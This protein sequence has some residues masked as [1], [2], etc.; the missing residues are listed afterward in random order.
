MPAEPSPFDELPNYLKR[1]V[2]LVAQGKTN[3][4]IAAEACLAPHTVE[5]YVS[6]IMERTG[7]RTRAKLVAEPIAWVA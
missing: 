4:E 7:F 2:P 3:Q 1:V 6:E 5:S